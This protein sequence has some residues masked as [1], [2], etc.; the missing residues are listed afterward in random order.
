MRKTCKTKYEAQPFFFF[1]FLPSL[2]SFQAVKETPEAAVSVKNPSDFSGTGGN[3]F[4]GF[5]IEKPEAGSVSRKETS[6]QAEDSPQQTRKPLTCDRYVIY[7]T[8]FLFFF[9]LFNGLDIC[10]LT[11]RTLDK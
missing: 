3:A 9:L 5:A 2:W 10:M 4:D 11:Y 8:C 7:C 6:S 1:F